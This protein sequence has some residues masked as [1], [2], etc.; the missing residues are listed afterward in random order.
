MQ[1][2]DVRPFAKLRTDAEKDSRQAARAQAFPKAVGGVNKRQ[3]MPDK[4]QKGQAN[5]RAFRC[6]RDAK[7]KSQYLQKKNMGAVT[8]KRKPQT[9]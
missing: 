1:I 8:R 2:F 3:T 9:A 5:I 7:H 6:R 4:R